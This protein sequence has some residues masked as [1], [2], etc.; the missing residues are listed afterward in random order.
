MNII[1]KEK[2]L[3]KVHLQTLLKALLNGRDLK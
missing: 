1:L 3:L 2:D